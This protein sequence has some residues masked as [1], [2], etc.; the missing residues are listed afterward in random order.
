M[1]L[2]GLLKAGW[3]NL[4]TSSRM[5]RMGLLAMGRTAKSSN[6]GGNEEFDLINHSLNLPSSRPK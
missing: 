6:V 1:G 2:A 4:V 5:D 3:W